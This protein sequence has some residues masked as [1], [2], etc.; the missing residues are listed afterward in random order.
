M[1]SRKKHG[2]DGTE[3]QAPRPRGFEPYYRY[4]ARVLMLLFV[5]C[6]SCSSTNDYAETSHLVMTLA[7]IHANSLFTIKLIHTGLNRM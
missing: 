5:V 2:S 1:Y 4:L 6:P 7:G 3:F